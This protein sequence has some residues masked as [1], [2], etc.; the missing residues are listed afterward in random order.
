MFGECKTRRLQCHQ[1]DR[2]SS[3]I[4]LATRKVGPL[5]RFSLLFDW[6]VEGF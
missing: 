2:A 4:T 5:S 6:I 3:Y 1:I